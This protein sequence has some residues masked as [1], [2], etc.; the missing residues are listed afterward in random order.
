MVE[1]CDALDAAD[2]DVDVDAGVPADVET[3][4]PPLEL[5]VPAAGPPEDI[6][7][8]PMGSATGGGSDFSGLWAV[9]GIAP[10]LWLELEEDT[11]ESPVPALADELDEELETEP[12]EE[13]A[14]EA[15]PD[16]VAA[17]E[18]CCEAELDWEFEF[19]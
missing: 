10:E 17:L 3:V 11:L 7:P 18:L 15:L 19:V 14:A 8:S 16:A 2:A 12:D 4:P 9:L 5:L 13:P 6:G 1:A